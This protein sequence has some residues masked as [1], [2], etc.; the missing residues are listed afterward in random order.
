MTVINQ[1]KTTPP[2]ASPTEA[3]RPDPEAHLN[4]MGG[5]S[6]DL[7]NPLL[8]LY[9]VAA[10]SFFG[11]PSY[12]QKDASDK[13][14]TRNVITLSPADIKHLT[15]TLN[16]VNPQEWREM[17]PAQMMEAAIDAALDSDY[18]GTL[19]LAVFL[20]TE[21]HIRTTPQVILV[22]AANHKS[23]KGTG[24]VRQLAPKIIG[25]P[26]DVTTGMAYQIERYGKPIPNSLKKSWADALQTFSAYQMA[27][28]R[29][30]SRKVSL[31]NVV[32]LTHPKGEVVDA[33]MK[34]TLTTADSTW[35]SIISVGGSTRENWEKAFE[36]M[37]HMALL[38]NL[39]NMTEKGVDVSQLAAKLRE[40]AVKGQQ[41]PFR[42]LSA[43][44]ALA[45]APNTVS[46]VIM[47][48]LEDCLELSIGNLPTFFGPRDVA[49]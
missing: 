16:D 8:R 36:V 45:A 46:P 28:Y 14:P 3:Q 11:E 12:Y 49:L 34:H 39:R 10:S 5:T 25:R 37:G 31:I 22:R 7:T 24:W 9:I 42:Y 48:V 41:L 17:T 1:K 4:F 38:R 23:V 6:Y 47:D 15:E 32:G 35:E 29:M 2:Q 43:S 26:D 19:K 30:D 20:R 27:K 18:I 40:G 21:E 44:K 33:L 13:R